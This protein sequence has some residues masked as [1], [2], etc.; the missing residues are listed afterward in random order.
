MK[1]VERFLKGIDFVNEKVGSFAAYLT[2]FMMCIVT[3]EV[4]ARYVFNKPTIW[5]MEINQFL[6][7][8]LTALTGGYTLLYKGHVNVEILYARFGKRT[9]AFIDI[10]TSFFFFSFIIV[11]LW[12]SGVMAVEAWRLGERSETL[13]S[14]PLF[15]VKVIIPIG[16]FLIL[17]QGFAQFIRNFITLI[18]GKEMERKLPG[19]FERER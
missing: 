16:A 4:V 10:I 17:I 18:T 9:R 11:L 19:L 2:F 7:C 8:G 6:L 12:K 5:A 13:F 14:P 15:P 3:Y 1:T